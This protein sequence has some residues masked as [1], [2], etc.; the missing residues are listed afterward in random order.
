MKN[1]PT[2]WAAPISMPNGFHVGSPRENPLPSIYSHSK[3]A[4]VHFSQ[5]KIRALH[6]CWIVFGKFASE[7]SYFIKLNGQMVLI[8]PKKVSSFHLINLLKPLFGWKC[9]ADREIMVG[10]TLVLMRTE[11]RAKRWH[12]SDMRCSFFA[13]R[14]AKP[15]RKFKTFIII[16]WFFARLLIRLCNHNWTGQSEWKYWIRLPLLPSINPERT[17]AHKKYAPSTWQIIKCDGPF[18]FQHMFPMHGKQNGM[19]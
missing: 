8:C 15:H 17:N 7:T 19:E 14:T 11:T 6:I 5:A 2:Y 1:N 13:I 16:Y 12:K 9:S 3:Y 10:K 18:V 4:M